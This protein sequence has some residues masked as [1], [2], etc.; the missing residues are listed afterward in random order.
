[1]PRNRRNPHHVEGPLSLLF[2]PITIGSLS[3]RNRVMRSA[4]AERLA[5]PETGA[6]GP[7]LAAMY[8]ALAEGGVGLIVTGHAYVHRGGKAHSE[9]AS[10]ADDA[11]IDAWRAVVRPAQDAGARV[12]MQ[13]NHCGASCDPTVTPAPI[14]PSGI[15]TND[16]VSPRAMTQGEI[17]EVVEA[18]GRAAAR[19]RAAGLDGVQIHAAHGYLVSQFLTP[20]TNRREDAWGGDPGRRRATLGAVLDAVRRHAGDDYPLWVKLGV[21]GHA[22]SGLTAVEGA[23]AAVVAFDHGADCVEVSHAL[24]VPEELAGNGEANFLPLARAVRDAV[25]AGQ[26]LALV[27]RLRSREVMD[28]VLSEGVAQLVSLCRPLILEP[29]LPNR[30]RNGAASAARC[31]RCGRCWPAAPGEGVGCHNRA[32]RGGRCE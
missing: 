26:P 17:E 5:A 20:S 19:A 6:P 7:R 9:M 21:A 29:D 12:I 15:A 13:I 8:H 27:S 24:G 30:L 23:G 18:F 22:S 31:V 2:E 32:M 10:I 3:L 11:V 14:S 25:G 28:A 16:N 1:M 4:T